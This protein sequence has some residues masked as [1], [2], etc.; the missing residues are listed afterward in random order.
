[1]KSKKKLYNRHYT[2]SLTHNIYI[3]IESNLEWMKKNP[4]IMRTATETKRTN[5]ILME[6][7]LLR[8]CP[9]NVSYIHYTVDWL[10]CRQ[11]ANY[12]VT[13]TT[14]LN[15]STEQTDLFCFCG[16]SLCKITFRSTHTH[17]WNSQ[18]KRLIFRTGRFVQN[19]F[20]SAGWFAYFKYLKQKNGKNLRLHVS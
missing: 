10:L 18:N 7:E 14:I 8:S 13:R 12:S 4:I 6:T 3:Y 2:N 20:L 11:M 5:A 17:T 15:S 16:F 1:M 19:D 9:P